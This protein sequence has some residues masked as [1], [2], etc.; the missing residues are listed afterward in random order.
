[1]TFPIRR[2]THPGNGTNEMIRLPVLREAIESALG[3]L[4]SVPG[5]IKAET[6]L[7]KALI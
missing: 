5:K 1:M 6:T 3:T 2:S 4:G 7:S